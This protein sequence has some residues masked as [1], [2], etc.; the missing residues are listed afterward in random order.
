MIPQQKNILEEVSFGERPSLTYHMDRE[1]ERIMADCDRLEAMKQAVYKILNTQRYDCPIYS[2][3][4]GVE[5]KDL[6]G[7]PAGYC[8]LEIERRVTE[9]L[10]QDDRVKRVCDF[11]FEL[12]EKKVVHASFTVETTQGIFET[13]KEV[14]I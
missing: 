9:A 2:W 3:N 4:Y 14:M 1:S 7:M 13:E 12:P 11:E 8:M 10:M 6:T 5:L